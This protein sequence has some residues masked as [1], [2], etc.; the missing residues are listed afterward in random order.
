VASRLQL[1]VFCNL[2][3][4]PLAV[5]SSKLGIAHYPHARFVKSADVSHQTCDSVNEHI[6]KGRKSV[7]SCH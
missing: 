4:S 3:G 2:G 7:R 6:Y 5:F 1:A